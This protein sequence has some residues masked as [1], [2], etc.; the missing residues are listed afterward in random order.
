MNLVDENNRP[1]N[2][3]PKK[4]VDSQ[5]EAIEKEEQQKPLTTREVGQAFANHLI[6]SAG[7]LPNNDTINSQFD[8]LYHTALNLLG[9]RILNVGLGMEHGNIIVEWDS[10]RAFAC[11]KEVQEDLTRTIGEWK[12]KFMN[13]ELAYHPGK[14]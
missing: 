12:D 10:S 4:L 1:L 9:H 7:Q 2:A 8:V 6:N 5:G 11:E 14:N 13:G 3:E